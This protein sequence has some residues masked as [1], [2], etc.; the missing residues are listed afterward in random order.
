MNSLLFA[1]AWYLRGLN[2]LQEGK[3]KEEKGDSGKIHFD[4]ASDA[5]DRAFQ[6]LDPKDNR[7]AAQALKAHIQTLCCQNS[8]EAFLKALSLVSQLLN[9]YRTELFLNLMSQTKSTSF[10]DSLLPI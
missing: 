3:A 10:K 8:R 4:Q 7:Y 9:V 5:L 2:E 6:S 1:K